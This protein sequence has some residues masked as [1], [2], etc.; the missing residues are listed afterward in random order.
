MYK[1]KHNVRRQLFLPSLSLSLSLS[2]IV[3]LSLYHCSLSFIGF[4]PVGVA[5]ATALRD[6]AAQRQ[7][8]ALKIMDDEMSNSKGRTMKRTLDLREKSSLLID[9]GLQL[10][11]RFG[12]MQRRFTRIGRVFLF[13]NMNFHVK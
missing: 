2:L 12:R 5:R 1:L 9:I 6:R 13:N 7:I 10:E 8:D 3:L 4:R 11:R